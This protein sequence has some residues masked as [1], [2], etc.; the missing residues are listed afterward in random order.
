MA[1]EKS[2]DYNTELEEKI[3]MILRQ[4]DYNEE[5]VREKMIE[6]NGDH[7]AIIKSFL[8]ISEKKEQPIKTINQ[9]IYRQIRFKL[10]SS[11]REYNQ[12]KQSDKSV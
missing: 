3:Q 5:Q 1:T 8:G 2:F 9:E 11:M 10:D 12:R 7:I 6:F 4:T